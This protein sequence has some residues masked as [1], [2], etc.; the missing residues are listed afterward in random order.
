M[1]AAYDQKNIQDI[2]QFTTPEVYAEIHLQIQERGEANNYTEVVNVE[3]ELLET[4]NEIDGQAQTPVTAASVR[5]S[6]ML[7]E[8][9][10]HIPSSFNEVWHFRKNPETA[11]WLVAGVQ[12]H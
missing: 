3:A 7:R 11:R 5:F 6:G 9:F 1:Q 10:N 4:A 2:R 12:Q 8:D